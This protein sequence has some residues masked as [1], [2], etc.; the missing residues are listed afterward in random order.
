MICP[1]CTTENPNSN[2]FCLACGEALREERPRSGGGSAPA[3]GPVAHPAAGETPAAGAGAVEPSPG[4]AELDPPPAVEAAADDE[5]E[6]KFAGR[7]RELR[8]IGEGAMATV[9]RALDTVLDQEVALKV[10]HPEQ[11]ANRSFIARFKR[12][13]ALAR[14]ITHPNVYRIYDIGQSGN[15]HFISME[16]IRGRELKECCD[17]NPMPVREGLALARQIALALAEAHA[18]GIVHRDLKPQNIMLEEGTGRAVVMDFGIAIGR[19]SSSITQLGTFVGTPEYISP[20]QALGGTVDLR[21]DIYALGVIMY[22]LFTGRLPFGPGDPLSVALSHIRETPE[23]PGRLVPGL[24]PELEALILRAMAR[25]PEQRHPSAAALVEELDRLCRRLDCAP[26]EGAETEAPA[27][28][29]PGSSQNPYLNRA[30]IRDKRFFFGRRKELATIYSRLGAARPQSVSIVGERRIGKSSL[31]SAINDPDN[32]R[33]HLRDPESYLFIFMDFQEKR[34]A[35]VEEFFASLF[36]ALQAEAG[37]RAGQL[38]EAG[39]DGF[40]QVCERL[41]RQRMKLVLLFDEFEAVTKNRNFD[42]E[43][44]AFLRSVANNYNVA[45]VTSSLKNL[46]EL[47]HNREISDSPFFNIFSNLN[48]GPF[49]EKEALQFVSEPSREYGN[50][51]GEHFETVL[52]LSGYF[53]F[54]MAI[55]CSILLDFDFRQADPR[56]T[57]FENVEELFLEEAQMHFQFILNGLGRDELQACRRLAAGDSLNEID[58]YVVKDLLRRG[59]LIRGQDGELRLFSR[60]FARMLEE[61][62]VRGRGPEPA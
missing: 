15:T 29:F 21:T 22:E 37:E 23:P 26:E 55:A 30:M 6:K 53:P 40:K 35:R 5:S 61:H 41:D 32:R 58:R 52:E 11:A 2:W 38:P 34:R 46:Q 28:L 48:L 49:T 31:L 62:L 42:P 44:F 25:D 19:Q 3:P 20:E 18:K 9:F 24:P 12:E 17:G 57:V 4:D 1:H 27:P 8:R 51:L 13:I 60:T 10:L 14:T 7:Y 59:Y 36:Q 39:Y 33:A 45:Y 43:F 16:Y 56:K 47:C 50:P 54:Y